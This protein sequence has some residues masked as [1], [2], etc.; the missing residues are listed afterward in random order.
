MTLENQIVY[1]IF[2]T[3]LYHAN[4]SDYVNDVIDL[5][6]IPYNNFFDNLFDNL[7]IF[8]FF[9]ILYDTIDIL[10]KYSLLFKNIYSGV[11]TGIFRFNANFRSVS[12]K[13]FSRPH[14][15]PQ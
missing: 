8:Q 4:V 9:D 15:S 2:S 13:S 14:A 10:G 3:P 1:P 11:N 5:D 7:Y 12:L 6:N